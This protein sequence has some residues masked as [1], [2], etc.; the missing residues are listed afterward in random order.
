MR[1]TYFFV[2]AAAVGAFL[3]ASQPAIGGG[4]GGNQPPVVGFG[5]LITVECN[6]QGLSVHSLD[7]GAIDPDGDSLTYSWSLGQSCAG[8]G[9]LDD[10]TLAMPTLTFDMAGLCLD[11]CG[12]INLSVSDGINP[13]VNVNGALLIQ[14]TTPPT[15]TCPPDIGTQLWQ[16]GPNGGP[17][18]PS[19]SVANTGMA[20]GSDNCS[21][22]T[23]VMTEVVTLFPDPHFPQGL[24]AEIVRTWNIVGCTGSAQSCTQTITLVGPSFFSSQTATI[25]IDLG[26]NP[27][28]LSVPTFNGTP[29]VPVEVLVHGSADFSVFQL[30]ARKLQLSRW[31]S[32]G[33]VVSPIS[34]MVGDFGAPEDGGFDHTTIGDGY[35]DML[36]RFDAQAVANAFDLFVEPNGK[37]LQLHLSGSQWNGQPFVAKDVVIVQQ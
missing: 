7:A 35:V 20:T 34:V 30:V 3:I 24:E 5:G 6:G 23:P 18:D 4:G 33:Q 15:L 28:F 2:P 25:D 11:E 36:F 19:V 21:P 32:V 37:A 26:Q 10:S 9:S 14:D 1:A 17:N 27:S 13:P 8:Q 22:A 16:G 31:D 29:A 12:G